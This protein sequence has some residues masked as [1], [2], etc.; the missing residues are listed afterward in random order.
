MSKMLVLMV[1]EVEAT[2]ESD[3]V[4]L[5]DN[6][7]TIAANCFEPGQVVLSRCQFQDVKHFHLTEANSG[8]VNMI[9]GELD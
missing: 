3:A 6:Y 5:L 9:K 8:V 2:N 4:W 1:A 7:R